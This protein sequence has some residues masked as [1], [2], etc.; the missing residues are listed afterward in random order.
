MGLDKF[1]EEVE[2]RLGY[3]LEPAREFKFSDNS[4]RYGWTKG[5]NNTWNYCMFIQNGR[6]RDTPGYPLKTALKEIATVHKGDFR[7][8]PNPTLDSWQY[9]GERKGNYHGVVEEI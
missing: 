5:L 1:R 8:T 3:K 4:D 7:L 2:S 9:T 6:I